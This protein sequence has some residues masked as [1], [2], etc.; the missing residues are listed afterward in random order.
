MDF[1]ETLEERIEDRTLKFVLLDYG[2]SRKV[3]H[4]YRRFFRERLQVER[5]LEHAEQEPV[6]AVLERLAK[7]RVPAGTALTGQ[8]KLCRSPLN[9]AL[10][11][12][13][14]TQITYPRVSPCLHS[15]GAL[16]SFSL[17]QSAI[18]RNLTSNNAK[19]QHPLT[20]ENHER[21]ARRLAEH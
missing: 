1:L 13:F 10:Q 12:L 16:R 6:V 3:K 5:P 19:Q 4:A 18:S 2:T 14:Q 11:Q 20:T 7:A 17:H 8:C 9:L 15:T 21:L